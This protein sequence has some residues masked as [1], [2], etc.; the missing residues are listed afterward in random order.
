M[1]ILAD[2]GAKRT[3]RIF[4]GVP[5]FLKLIRAMLATSPTDRPKAIEVRDRL[6]EILSGTCGKETL[7]CA[8][9]VWEVIPVR[10]DSP[11]SPSVSRTDSMNVAA[12]VVDE[13]VIAIMEGL[14]STSRCGDDHMSVLSKTESKDTSKTTSRRGSAASQNGPRFA[15]WRR[16]FSRS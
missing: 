1:K 14:R 13:E 15:S 11:E 6:E 3:E 5:D 7:C 2:E 16:K 4:R 12:E 8:D 10:D 9:R